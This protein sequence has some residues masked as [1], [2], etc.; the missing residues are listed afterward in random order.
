MTFAI[1]PAA[2]DDQAFIT[3]MQYDACFVPPG[4]EPFP[5]EV[6]DDPAIRPYHAGFGT[7]P[8]DVGVIAE[9]ATGIAGSGDRALGAAW[10]RQVRGYGFVDDHTPELGIAVVADRRGEGIGASMLGALFDHVP[11]CSLSC[12]LRNP[13]VGLYERFG[14]EVVRRDGEHT[15][16]MLRDPRARL[17]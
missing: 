11:R 13:A 12:D 3:E 2:A 14:F 16:V 10:V 8:G 17:T 6:L 4:A 1:R 15:V 9:I 5:R 7:R